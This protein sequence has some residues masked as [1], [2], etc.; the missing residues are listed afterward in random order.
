MEWPKLKNIIILILLLANLF[1]LAMVG[2]Q[3]QDSARYQEQA[4]HNAASVLERNG[5]TVEKDAVSGEAAQMIL[6][7]A[8]DRE[9]EEKLASALLGACT[10][11]DLGGGRY[12]YEGILGAAEF[13]NNGNFSVTFPE[14]VQKLEQSQNQ[15][16][17]ILDLLK[18]VGISCIPTDY[19]MQGDESIYTLVQT[20]EGMPV[21]SCQI[22]AVY[23]D[24]AL[25]TISGQ[26]LMGTPRSA[27]DKSEVISVPTA[28]LR[29]LNGINDLNDICTQIVAMDPGYLLSTS[30]EEIRMI[31]I[32][33]VQT[34][35]G[36]YNLNGLTGVLERAQYGVRAVQAR[37]EA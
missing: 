7:V 17:H 2:I 15:Q 36:T 31:P 25:K 10:V 29:V 26:R 21:Y 37:E 6:A 28:M 12:S 27:N 19:Q 34:D 32:W 20:W 1:L 13:R 14:G 18:Q 9:S 11:S 16:Q 8:R 3:K 22:T 30:E 23:R 33:Y 4:L 35:T 5:I 24:S